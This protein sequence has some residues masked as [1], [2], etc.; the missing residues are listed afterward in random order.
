MVI[1]NNLNGYMIKVFGWMFLGLLL[2]G[3]TA[4][5]VANN[6]SLWGVFSG[7]AF[8]IL[9]LLQLGLVVTISAFLRKLPPIVAKVLFIL[10]SIVS[11]V[12]FSTIFLVYEIGSIF[13]IFCLTSALFGGLAFLG[14]QMKIDL[15]KIGTL[16][17]VGLVVGFILMLLNIFVFGS[18][19]MSVVL[20]WL[21]LAIFLGLTV[22]DMQKIKAWYMANEHDEKMLEK[23]AIFGALDLYLDFINIMIKLL[24]LFGR[25]RD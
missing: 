8:F 22:Y 12:T 7:G 17:T 14:Y 19:M 13:Q 24:A 20:T 15:T 21:M 9:I 4:G 2:T 23:I 6:E 18:D 16:L 1:E 5:V 11:G 25:R 3:L 10:Y